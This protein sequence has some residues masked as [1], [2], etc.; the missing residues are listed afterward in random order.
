MLVIIQARS[1]S[2]RFR[3]KILFPIYK[4]PLINHVIEK[5]KKSKNK[6]NIVVSTSLEK[7]DNKF[8]KYLKKK[9][10]SFYRGSLN[11]V[12]LRL[13]KTAKKNNSKY[14]VRISGD[15]PLFDFRILDKAI[16]L[17]INIKILILLQMCFLEHIQKV[18]LLK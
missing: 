9:K 1:S 13:Y 17:R 8:T 10:I 12:A 15:S 3:N 11:N 7:S 4:K 16:K 5:I 18:N 6:L 14:F 2:K